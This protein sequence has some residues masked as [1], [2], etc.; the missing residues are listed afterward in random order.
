[1]KNSAVESIMQL[2]NN[3]DYVSDILDFLEQKIVTPRGYFLF[4][5]NELGQ[6]KP[7]DVWQ[8]YF[9]FQD[10]IIVLEYT[11]KGEKI[12]HRH[13][14]RIGN[15]A[16]IKRLENLLALKEEEF[17]N[18]RKKVFKTRK[19]FYNSF[20]RKKPDFETTIGE[21]NIRV[22]RA[23]KQGFVNDV[24]RIMVMG[25]EELCSRSIYIQLV[26]LLAEEGKIAKDQLVH[27]YELFK[28]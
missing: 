2:F 18:L 15:E 13:P 3:V 12:V 14:S 9:P 20:D 22:D 19:S 21:Y 10:E 6:N 16:D 24:L 8:L 17:N 4:S 27:Y 5:P 26:D 7:G 11:Q 23:N 28:D 25:D 1:M